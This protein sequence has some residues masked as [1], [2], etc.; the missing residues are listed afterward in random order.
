MKSREWLD[1][2]LESTDPIEQFSNS[3]R[4]FN[5]LFYTNISGTE[6]DKIK[7]YIDRE[8]TEEMATELLASHQSE[9]MYLTSIPVKDMR[10]HGRDTSEYISTYKNTESAKEKLKQIFSIIYKVRCNLEHG[11]KS[12]TRDRDIEL[13]M[14]SWPLVAEVIDR[15]A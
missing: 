2:G 6:L 3:W 4:G 8:V 11:Q 15:C 13:C 5:N 12:P 7:L 14:S 10:G 1:R 9:I